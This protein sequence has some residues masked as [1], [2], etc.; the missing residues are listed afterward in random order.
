MLRG[1]IQTCTSCKEK[2]KMW[3]TGLCRPC[4]D[5][6]NRE[7]IREQRRKW[8]EKNPEKVN[9]EARSIQWDRMMFGGNRQK[10][11]E[12]DNFECQECGLTQETHFAL[13]NRGLSVHHLDETGVGAK[14]GEKNNDLDNLITLCMRCHGKLH[15]AEGGRWN[16]GRKKTQKHIK[17]PSTKI[18]SELKNSNTKVKPELKNSSKSYK[19]DK[20]DYEADEEEDFMPS[21]PEKIICNDCGSQSTEGKK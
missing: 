9:K 4:Y 8:K 13:F 16:K 17:S 2:K 11:L 5:N 3:V 1:K 6:V 7:R 18:K 14:I 10:A 19:C 20:C 12:R 15:G 21:T